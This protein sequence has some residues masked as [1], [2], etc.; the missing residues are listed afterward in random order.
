MT[1]QQP[2]RDEF[3]AY[4][5]EARTSYGLRVFLPYIGFLGGLA[6]YGFAVHLLDAEARF[7]VPSVVG[8][9]A[10]LI[11]LPYFLIKRGRKRYGKFICCPQCGDWF[12]EDISGAYRG[13]NPKFEKVIQTG[14]CCKCGN[15]IFKE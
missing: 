4:W 15:Q 8:F 3:I 7:I 12:A 2:T 9:F 1:T 11:F 13:D 14:K 5:R 10:Y 6:I